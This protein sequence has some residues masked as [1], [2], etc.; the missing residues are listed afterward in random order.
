MLWTGDGTSSRSVDL[1][2]SSDLVWAKKR[3]AIQSHQLADTVRGSNSVL[4]SNSTDEAKD[5]ETDFTGGG[6]SSISSTAFTISQGSSNNDNLNENSGTF[7]AW[8]WDAG[9]TTTTVAKD[10]NG[11]NLPGATCEYRANTTNGFS[12]VKVA[13]PQSN[14]ARVHGLGVAPDFFI[15]KS[16]ASADSWHTYWKVLGYTKYINLNATSAATSSDQFG[17]QEPDSTYFYVKAN[18]GSG[19]NKAGGMVY[20]LW[21][22]VEGYSAFGSYTGNG[23]ADGPFVYTGFRVAWLLIKNT[24]TG[25]E[26][27]T[28]HDSTRDVDNPA[29][30]RLLPNDTAAGS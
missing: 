26:T 27:W 13:D 15:C 20:Y 30:H 12:V 25:G 22:A 19:A 3:S 28:I 17:S 8:T 7:V 24:T 23:D 5:P 2:I 6:I 11:T 1:P 29:E 4:K 14:E 10:A 9:D 18:T 21:S 16:T